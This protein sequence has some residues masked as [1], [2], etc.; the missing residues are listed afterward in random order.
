MSFLPQFMR[1]TSWKLFF[2][3]ISQLLPW[4]NLLYLLQGIQQSVVRVPSCLTQL[5]DYRN[6]ELF[7]LFI[8]SELHQDCWSLFACRTFQALS[9]YPIFTRRMLRQSDKF[10]CLWFDSYSCTRSAMARTAFFYYCPY[11]TAPQDC[12]Q[13]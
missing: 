5:Y 13:R 12:P 9:K 11:C 7:Q 10:L 1:F 3:R 4:I 6:W 8:F 2:Q